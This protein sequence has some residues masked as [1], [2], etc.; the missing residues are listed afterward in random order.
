[1][2][3]T[4][5]GTLALSAQAPRPDFDA[6]RPWE[7]LVRPSAV[8]YDPASAVEGRIERKLFRGEQ[9]MCTV[10]LGGG[11]S[12]LAMVPSHHGHEVGD[13]IRISARL[14][15]EAVFPPRANGGRP[16]DDNCAI[17]S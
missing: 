15:G 3:E 13:R 10:R 1:M 2:L 12:V 14:Q 8:A 6:G 16:C 11:E 5:L 7:V 17:S 9:S 4:S